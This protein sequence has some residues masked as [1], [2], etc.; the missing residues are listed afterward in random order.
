MDLEVIMPFVILITFSFG[1]WFLWFKLFKIIGKDWTWAFIMFVP[2]IS[3]V[4][5]IWF[6][7]SGWPNRPRPGKML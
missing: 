1:W 3:W 6:I 2:V 4:V 7:V 5:I